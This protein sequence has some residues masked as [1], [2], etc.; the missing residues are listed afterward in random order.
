MS[1]DLIG[2]IAGGMPC[3]QRNA[4][5]GRVRTFKSARVPTKAVRRVDEASAAASPARPCLADGSVPR[6]AG[7]WADAQRPTML[8]LTA[9]CRR[10]PSYRT[11][12][13]WDVFGVVDRGRW[14]RLRGA[15][16]T[17]RHEAAYPWA[18]WVTVQISTP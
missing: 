18:A 1:A 4:N 16:R 11:C 5:P 12:R 15:G 7:P 10:R 6:S 17:G 14:R 13:E 3:P 9:A 8:R 2:V